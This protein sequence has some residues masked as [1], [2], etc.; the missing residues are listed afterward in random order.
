[1]PRIPRIFWCLWRVWSDD[2]MMNVSE[3]LT[4]PQQYDSVDVE[5]PMCDVCE[6]TFLIPFL[7]LLPVSCTVVRRFIIVSILHWIQKIVQRGNLFY[8]GTLFGPNINWLLSCSRPIEGTREYTIYHFCIYRC[9]S[10]QLQ[11]YVTLLW[12]KLLI[13]IGLFVNSRLNS[14]I[15]A[16]FQ[17]IVCITLLNSNQNFLSLYLSN[18]I[19]IRTAFFGSFLIFVVPF[20]KHI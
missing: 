4:V 13:F 10:R 15:N 8:K 12:W 17:V 19:S 11:Q 14:F 1:L 18:L 7:I 2:R 6:R 16:I 3:W 20:I 5:I 9:S